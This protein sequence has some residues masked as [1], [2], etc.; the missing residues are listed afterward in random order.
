[1]MGLTQE[2]VNI[3]VADGL[4]NND[5]TN[6]SRTYADIIIKNVLTPFNIILFMIGASL[7][8]CREPLSAVS[9]TG[10]IIINILIATIQEIRAKRRL[11]K[12]ALLTRPKVKVI[13]DEKEMVIDQYDIVKDDVIVLRSG[14]QALVDGEILVCKSIEM[15][16]SLLTGESSTV[17]KDVG[18]I[19]YS[20]SIC[21]TGECYYKV[22][23]FGD[24]S[25]ASQMLNS[26]R[27][28]ISKKT[29]LQMETES[30]TKVL[31]L[32]SVVLIVASSIINLF[33][34]R[35]YSM[36]QTLETFVV[37]LDIV[38]VALFLLITMAYMIAA[39]RMADS[40]ILLQRSNSVESMSHVDTV[41]MDKTGTITTNKLV[42]ERAINLIDSSEA[43]HLISI[44][45][46]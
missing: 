22:T 34:G 44:F 15:D 21:I 41:C 33:L 24:E 11:D 6:S 8:F 2:D 5:K 31:M 40:G 19:I 38:P 36:G 37:C 1:M 32:I 18:N 3:R 42:F 27:K 16:E 30:I 13:R 14:D 29:P 39:V 12:I 25:Y 45:V 26:A 7:L 43:S 17:R 20:G 46:S 35:T 28:F 4:V 9:A 10:I 23:A